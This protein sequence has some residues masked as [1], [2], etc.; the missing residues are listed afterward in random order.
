MLGSSLTEV[1]NLHVAAGGEILPAIR[2]VAAGLGLGVA[3][4]NGRLEG[5]WANAIARD[6]LTDLTG[7]EPDTAISGLFSS[8]G[9]F[10][11][12]LQRDL[13]VAGRTC[14]CLAVDLEHGRATLRTAVIPVVTGDGTAEAM[15]LLIP[16]EGADPP[17]ELPVRLGAWQSA[18][19]ATPLAVA[20]TLPSGLVRIRGGGAAPVLAGVRRDLAELVRSATR[21]QIAEAQRCFREGLSVAGE[22]AVTLATP[23]GG[24]A[25]GRLMWLTVRFGER[26]LLKVDVLRPAAPSASESP[27]QKIETDREG[28]L[29]ARCPDALLLL[30]RGR[31]MAGSPA[32]AEILG[33]P[34][35]EL[36]GRE[37]GDL[38]PAGD[39]RLKSVCE[40]VERGLSIVL[41]AKLAIRGSD[42]G[43]REVEVR[44]APVPDSP[45]P[46]A[47]MSVRPDDP[48]ASEDELSRIAAMLA[49][50]DIA[51]DDAGRLRG[52][53]ELVREEFRADWIEL[54]Q[55]DPESARLREVYAEPVL[56]GREELHATVP[57]SRLVDWYELLTV[58]PGPL[59][60]DP[61]TWVPGTVPEGAEPPILALVV[62]TFSRTVWM[63]LVA[64]SGSPSPRDAARLRRSG[65]AVGWV[66]DRVLAQRETDRL[67]QERDV[68]LRALES[69]EVGF[70]IVAENGQV[71]VVTGPVLEALGATP[72]L[73]D[74]LAFHELFE[75][76]VAARL[77]A[78]LRIVSR[79]AGSWEGDVVA[80][81][82]WSKAIRLR[83]R[84]E[85]VVG[86]DGH[87][88]GMVATIWDMSK[89][90]VT[91]ATRE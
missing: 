21:E 18:L 25:R 27:D 43:S 13:D 81:S 76:E 70:V 16:A 33:W 44:I 22:A 38:Q 37:L 52:A 49:V 65:Q 60:V 91:K 28:V 69:A 87:S 56:Q 71:L 46:L 31:I 34:P 86:P 50:A 42:D 68:L 54:V 72:E 17:S 41:R 55:L 78:P 53:L 58:T 51:S 66:I 20:T 59:A 5:L 61:A 57:T 24:L 73:V 74:G 29:L 88:R 30:E 12:W 14:L 47:V 15:L 90:Q 23:D 83:L 36:V 84:F 67:L 79:D 26:V 82:R 77:S 35:D 39:G 32:V 75:D 4:V 63:L 11:R 9:V 45:E 64:C 48:A 8:S 7:L 40:R 10:P 3:A 85:A 2:E 89:G 62:P 1:L 80:R 19:D 6:R